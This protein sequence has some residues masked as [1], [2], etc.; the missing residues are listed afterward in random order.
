M[1]LRPH[2]ALLR[3]QRGEDADHVGAA[4]L[5][6]APVQDR[7]ADFESGPSQF[8]LRVTVSDERH[9]RRAAKAEDD[10]AQE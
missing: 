5:V 6:E 8:D 3:H 2:G 4:D 9:V 10:K 7:A 1:Q